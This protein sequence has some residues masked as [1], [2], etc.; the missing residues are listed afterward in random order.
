MSSLALCFRA[1]G[2][3]SAPHSIILCT[4]METITRVQVL[5]LR[6]E[7][8]LAE[9]W[10]YDSSLRPAPGNRHRATRRGNTRSLFVLVNETYCNLVISVLRTARPP[11]SRR[12]DKFRTLGLRVQE[13]PGHGAEVVAWGI[14]WTT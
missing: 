2:P 7:R 14:K 9:K 13:A 12:K 11:E 10:V 5:F 6:P 4:A 3:R 1:P 8:M